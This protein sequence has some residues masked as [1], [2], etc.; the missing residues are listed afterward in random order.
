MSLEHSSHGGPN[1]DAVSDSASGADTDDVSID[2][3]DFAPDTVSDALAADLDTACARIAPTWPLDRFIAVN[4]LWGWI[5]EPFPVVAAKAGALGGSALVP[6]RDHFR[7]AWRE[8]RITRDDLE[9]AA[10][11]TDL[12]VDALLTWLDEPSA[13]L[14]KR[15]TLV[16]LVDV[17]RGTHALRDHVV[18][19]L[20][21]HCASFFDERLDVD[22][23]GGLFASWKR[24]TL[25]DRAWHLGLHELRPVVASLPYDARATLERALSELAVP[26]SARADYLTSLLLDV[27]GWAAWCAYR[28]WTARLEGRDDDTIV[29]LLA[30]RI[31]WELRALRH[32]GRALEATWRRTQASWGDVDDAV[33]KQQRLAW[34]WQDA[35]ELAYQRPLARALVRAPDARPATT[36]SVQA[37]FCIDVR[38]EVFRR[39]LEAQSPSIATL[40]FAGFFGLPIDYLPLGATHARPQL[41]GLLAPKMHVTDTRAPEDAAAKRRDRLGLR[42]AWKALRS[43]ALSTFAFVDALGPLYA[44]ALAWRSAMHTPDPSVDHAGLAAHEHGKPRLHLGAD[45]E[46]LSVDA[47]CDLATNLL[48]GMSLVP[49]DGAKSPLARL[50]LLVGHGSATR[51]N[52]YAAGLDCGACCGQTGEVN[53]RAAAALLNDPAVRG[54]LRSR[55]L[56]VPETTHFVAALHVTTTDDVR[57]FDLDELPASHEAELATL[58]EQLRAAGVVA[59]AERAGRLGIEATDDATI[60]AAIRRRAGDWSEVRPE[61]GLARNAAFVIAPRTRTKELSL[62]GR[63]FLHE[64]VAERDEGFAVLELLLTAPMVVTHWINLQY[65]ASTVEP[66][67]YGSGNKVLH[68]VV[69]G[70][71][72]VFE[73]NGG[74]LRIGL[75]MQSVHDGTRFVHE[76][77]RLSVFVE[78]P[79][80]AI[81]T[82]LAKHAHVRALV[83][84]GWLHLFRL[85]GDAVW[86]RHAD[87]WRSFHDA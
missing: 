20:S 79:Q 66:R 60:E 31:A 72:G 76:P 74:D 30:I 33:A 55:G 85:E 2:V 3:S 14:P 35:L 36:P 12:S 75:P 37:A 43:G 61:W 39:A 62:D 10:A 49:T 22:R 41:P 78:A 38:S 42:T 80:D 71:L 8:E 64:Y 59:R 1:R 51:N 4:P 73:G 21:R 56:D 24:I 40:G 7:I 18:D 84:N 52:P 65:Y 27:G 25:R 86:R 17:E 57:L 26:P 47:R 87:G 82:I 48:R 69:G 54:G 6:D 53:A 23:E 34:I 28:R 44:G 32:G 15:A 16:D 81:D 29:E 58:R 50:V 63:A 70:T 11:G 68:D 77:L 9:R 67:R 46:P 45:G 13:P 19:E 83:E 5:Q